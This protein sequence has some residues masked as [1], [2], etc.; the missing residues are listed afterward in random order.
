MTLLFVLAPSMPV[1]SFSDIFG[2]F[3]FQDEEAHVFDSEH[4]TVWL[5]SPSNDS[6]T[7]QDNN[8]LSFTYNHT[9]SL[10][11]VVNCTLFMDGTAVNYAIAVAADTNTGVYS[12]TSI[13]EAAHWWWVNCTNGTAAESS[14]DVGGNWTITSDTTQPYVQLYSPENTTYPTINITLNYT[15]SDTHLNTTWYEYN[16]V[17]TTLTENTSFTALNNQQS[18]IILWANDTSGNI[19][20]TSVTFLVDTVAPSINLNS[21]IHGVILTNSTVNFNWTATDNSD[22]NITCNLTIDGTVNVSDIASLN[23]TPTNYTVDGLS[24]GVHYWNVTCRDNAN[25]NV[26]SETRSFGINAYP[27][28][29][30]T[31]GNWTISSDY[32]L[33]SSILCNSINISDDATL[34]IYE[35]EVDIQTDEFTINNGTLSHRANTNSKLYG[36]NITAG[37]ITINPSGSI[38]V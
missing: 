28:C 2:M 33:S 34:T 10:G 22:T 6:Y 36:I 25:N 12:N 17:N 14:V 29:P 37:N 31:T 16:S 9:G 8:T 21:P 18:T 26:T 3:G 4:H 15:S 5:V 24:D 32:L 13:S 20:S 35:T 19:N 27:L 7:N 30:D 1:F 11:G 38:D 23:V